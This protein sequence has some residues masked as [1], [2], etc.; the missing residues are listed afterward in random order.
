MRQHR[1]T[2]AV[3]APLEDIK[4]EAAMIGVFG[5][6]LLHRGDLE[7]RLLH[8]AENGN[9][10]A[11]HNLEELIGN[12][13]RADLLA[14]EECVRVQVRATSEVMQALGLGRYVAQVVGAQIAAL[15]DHVEAAGQ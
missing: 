1:A 4:A 12:K 2:E 10:V 6:Q 7:V 9:L 15:K 13:D 8:R 5:E 11:L 14:I 3:L